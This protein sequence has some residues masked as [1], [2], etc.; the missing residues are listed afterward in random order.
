MSC[1]S[2]S[3]CCILTTPLNTEHVIELWLSNVFVVKRSCWSGLVLPLNRQTVDFQIKILAVMLYNFYN[4]SHFQT[5]K[6]KSENIHLY[7]SEKKWT[8][9]RY[10]KQ[11]VIKCIQLFTSFQNRIYN[12]LRYGRQEHQQHSRWTVMSALPRLRTIYTLEVTVATHVEP[13]SGEQLRGW[14][15]LTWSAR[16][17]TMSASSQSHQNPAARADLKSASVLEWRGSCCRWY[18]TEGKKHND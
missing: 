5:F 11:K 13:S 17:G 6:E 18:F 10:M 9:Q 2:V 12:V 3:W 16:L 15:R 8:K 7:T 14:G 1:V 4:F